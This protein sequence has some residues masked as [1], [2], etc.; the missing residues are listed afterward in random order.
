MDESLPLLER[1]EAYYKSSSLH[2][3]EYRLEQ[4]RLK[5]Y[6]EAQMRKSGIPRSLKNSPED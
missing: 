3:P 5:E 6:F 4:C 1:R 2:S